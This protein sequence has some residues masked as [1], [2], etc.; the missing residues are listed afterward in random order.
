[1][2]LN[3]DRLGALASTLGSLLLDYN[4]LLVNKCFLMS[5]L[6]LSC[7]SFGPFLCVPSQGEE[8]S[9]SLFTSPPQEASENHEVTHQLPSRQRQ[10]PTPELSSQNIPSSPFTGFSSLELKRCLQNQFLFMSTNTDTLATASYDYKMIQSSL[11]GNRLI[12]SIGEPYYHTGMEEKE[13]TV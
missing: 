5:G 2:L 1:M 12:K 9:T 11:V 13:V 3:T 7:L 8:I 6:N 10:T 4:I